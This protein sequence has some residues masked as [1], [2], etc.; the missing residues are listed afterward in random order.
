ME[1]LQNFEQGYEQTN[2]KVRL[3]DLENYTPF[4]EH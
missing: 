2:E 3:I 4:F 1:N